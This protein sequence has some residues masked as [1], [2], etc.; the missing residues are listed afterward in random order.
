MTEIVGQELKQFIERIERLNEEKT[1]L[2]EDIKEI[3][4]EMKGRGFHTK[5]VRQLLRI[6]KQDRVERQ[7]M[8]AILDLYLTALGM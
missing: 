1:A 3:F 6:R 2:S 8:E 5:V 4:L 7:E